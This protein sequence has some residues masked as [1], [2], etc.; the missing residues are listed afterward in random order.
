MPKFYFR[1]LVRD[2][3]L[4]QMMDLKTAFRF[5]ANSELLQ[6]M[7]NKLVEEVAEV[8]EA[9]VSKEFEEEICD[10]L[11]VIDLLL[12]TLPKLASKASL[13]V[14][15]PIVIPAEANLDWYKNY[16]QLTA[17]S[18][19]ESYNTDSEK[20]I[21]LLLGMRYILFQLAQLMTLTPARI[22]AERRR[23]E[24]VAGSFTLGLWIE[25]ACPPEGHRLTNYMR[26]AP[27]K[28]PEEKAE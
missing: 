23:K 21:T 17:Q 28:Y 15:S 18:I 8:L 5:L 11:D 10:V 22:A 19:L 24:E 6:A 20:A 16:L 12:Q 13:I 1:K 2:K 26:K 14:H 7:I 27:H 4:D 9:T 3:N 25:Y